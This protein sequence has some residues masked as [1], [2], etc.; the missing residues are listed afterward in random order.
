M[1]Y[2]I[3]GKIIKPVRLYDA[4]LK[5]Q[6]IQEPQAQYRA[7]S[8]EGV[9]CSRI[10]DAGEYATKEDAEMKLAEVRKRLGQRAECISFQI[11]KAKQN[12]N[13]Q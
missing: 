4:A 5:R 10:A 8:Y 11:R 2:L 1:S 7:L 9:R 3:Y 12:S 6:A 13:L